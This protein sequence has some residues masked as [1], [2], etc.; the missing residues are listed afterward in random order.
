MKKFYSQKRLYTSVNKPMLRQLERYINKSIPPLLMLNL[1]RGNPNP[2]SDYITV[3][4]QKQFYGEFLRSIND[5]EQEHFDESVRTVSFELAHDNRFNFLGHKTI[6]IIINFD[7][8]T[9]YCHFSIAVNDEDGKRK[10]AIIEKDILEILQ[11]SKKP[12]VP[13]KLSNLLVD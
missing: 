5:Y 7:R 1:E 4:L 12:V 9:N 13:L 3:T 8:T 6:V 10:V 11:H 2:L